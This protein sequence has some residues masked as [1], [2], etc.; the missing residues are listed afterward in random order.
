MKNKFPVDKTKRPAA[1]IMDTQ[2]GKFTPVSQYLES[3]INA[4]RKSGGDTG[5][6]SILGILKEGVKNY[7]EVR[8]DHAKRVENR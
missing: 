6:G 5:P 8:E 3:I 1:K 4:V 7:E 2:K